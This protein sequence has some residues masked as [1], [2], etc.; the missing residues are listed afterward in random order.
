MTVEELVDSVDILEYISQFTEF[1]EKNGEYWA[2][3]PL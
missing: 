3:S 2:L 1:E